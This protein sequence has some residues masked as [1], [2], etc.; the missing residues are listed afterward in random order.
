AC[1]RPTPWQ[2]GLEER[3]RF[4]STRSAQDVS[5]CKTVWLE[6]R[7]SLRCLAMNRSARFG[8]V[9]ISAAPS[10][11]HAHFRSIGSQLLR[12]YLGIFVCLG[13]GLGISIFVPISVPTCKR[14]EHEDPH[15]PAQETCQ[16]VRYQDGSREEV[17][18]GSSTEQDHQHQLGGDP[19]GSRGQSEKA[20]PQTPG[21]QAAHQR[22]RK[23]NHQSG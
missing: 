6:A 18:F 12:Q 14:S 7:R 19:P 11:R 23:V 17:Y 20:I 4:F 5:S 8:T 1:N 2:R 3:H 15:K 21:W 22:A 10:S 16:Q 9:V 13:L